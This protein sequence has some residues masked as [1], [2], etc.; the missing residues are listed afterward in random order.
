MY[1][2]SWVAGACL[3]PPA[4]PALNCIFLRGSP[5]P[6]Q[7]WKRQVFHTTPSTT[8][9]FQTPQRLISTRPRPQQLISILH[10]DRFLHST[11]IDFYTP[12]RSISTLHKDWF[13]H[14]TTIDFDSTPSTTIDFHT[15]QHWFPH[16]PVH[17]D[18]YP[19]STT[20]DFHTPQRLISTLHTIPST[21]LDLHTT[22]STTI[23]SYST[24][25]QEVLG[26]LSAVGDGLNTS[27]VL[28]DH[29]KGAWV[30][31]WQRRRGNTVIWFWHQREEK[32]W[33]LSPFGAVFSV[34]S[35][36]FPDWFR[37]WKR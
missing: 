6:I 27:L 15:P 17:N 2:W 16:D 33:I 37:K 32:S 14:S 1:L 30:R 35:G 36:K 24:K 7:H 10:N 5:A 13:P 11:T 21:T 18:W 12:Q 22:P 8:I 20:I 23:D 9:D 28:V 3:P 19:H 31:W 26:N 25:T 4:H 29:I 34:M